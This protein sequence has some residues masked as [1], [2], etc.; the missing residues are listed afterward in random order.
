[1]QLP[2][3]SNGLY[4]IRKF[5]NVPEVL[6]EPGL[7]PVENF[8]KARTQTVTGSPRGARLEPIFSLFLGDYQQRFNSL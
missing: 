3:Q 2:V 6:S 1:M 8:R 7:T 5:T 4:D